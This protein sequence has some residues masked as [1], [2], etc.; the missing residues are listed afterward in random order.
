ME[1]FDALVIGSGAAGLYTALKLPV[2]WRVALITKEDLVMSSSDWAQG[3]IAAVID[4]TDS[5][6]LHVEDTLAAGA[7]L[8]ERTAVELLVE[9]AP[10]CIADLLRLGVGFD[11][12]QGHL[13]LTLE[14]AHSRKRIL[15]ARDATGRELVRALLEEVLAQPNI[16][17]FTQTLALDLWADQERC[18]GVSARYRGVVTYFGAPVTILATGGASRIF[19]HSTNPS[20]STGDGL[21]MAWRAGA[22]LRDL[23]FVQF[24]PT[25]LAVPGAPAFLIS[26]AVRGEGARILDQQGEYFLDR[27]HPQGELAPRD[28][29]ARAIY[30]H[31]KSLG[32]DRVYIDFRP[33]G[34]DRIQARF[35][36]IVLLCQRWGLDAL[37]DLIP[38]APAAHYC[39]GGVRTGLNGET[40]LVGLFAVGETASTGVHGAN[41]L[42][43]N[44]LLECL[45]F[46]Q[47]IAR[48]APK[49]TLDYPDPPEVSPT[50]PAPPELIQEIHR[51]LPL[52]CWQACGIVRTNAELSE[53]LERLSAWQEALDLGDWS[54]NREALEARNEV[55]LA[56]LMIRSALW[57]KESRGA[58]YR[59]DFPSPHADWQVHTLIQHQHWSAQPLG[60]IP[61]PISADPGSL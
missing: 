22:Q 10:A 19:A 23:E 6:G 57:R 26:E 55:I 5:F 61:S 39:M 48:F 14:A 3:G 40:S 13:D 42:A 9:E 12:Y 41:R 29:V 60:Q 15:H 27:Y 54:L 1:V 2:D 51:E 4:P 59:A 44:S 53:G 20:V 47:R 43:S 37:Q 50:H 24:H 38:V 34:L 58:H 56:Y 18:W 49:P 11:R 46:A 36:N 30:L 32:Q 16:T 8:C 25:A 7:G 31:L 35:P 21:A 17:V 52:L 45:V 33:I 28:V